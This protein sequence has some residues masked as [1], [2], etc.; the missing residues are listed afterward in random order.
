MAPA[1]TSSSFIATHRGRLAAINIQP[2]K[3]TTTN[4]YVTACKTNNCIYTLLSPSDGRYRPFS[5]ITLNNMDPHRTSTPF[6]RVSPDSYALDSTFILA[7]ASSNTSTSGEYSSTGHNIWVS[8]NWKTKEYKI[9]PFSVSNE[10]YDRNW[11]G[12]SED[13]SYILLDESPAP[14]IS[15]RANPLPT[16]FKSSHPD[17][18]RVLLFLEDYYQIKLTKPSVS[19]Y[20]SERIANKNSLTTS[21]FRRYKGAIWTKNICFSINKRLNRERFHNLIFPQLFHKDLSNR[22]ITRYPNHDMDYGMRSYRYTRTL[23]W[24]STKGF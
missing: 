16:T 12:R 21:A 2:Y 17:F 9:R 13:A 6:F 10:R 5:R 14:N 19:P 20:F 8:Y 15:Y 4:S 22:F 7:V 3:R 24:D 23:N 18:D 1:F 11:L